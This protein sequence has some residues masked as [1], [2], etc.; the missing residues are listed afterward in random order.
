[1]K[2]FVGC[3]DMMIGSGL[4]GYVDQTAVHLGE[5]GGKYLSGAA[6]ITQDSKTM[7]GRLRVP[8]W[9]DQDDR[10]VIAYPRH[11]VVPCISEDIQVTETLIWVHEIDRDPEMYRHDCHPM[12]FEAILERSFLKAQ[13]AGDLV[14]IDSMSSTEK[15]EFRKKAKSVLFTMP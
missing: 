7:D 9:S 13:A 8:V 6:S 14:V 1:M 3:A 4:Y 10:I 15:Q 5:T 2:P 12:S 11:L